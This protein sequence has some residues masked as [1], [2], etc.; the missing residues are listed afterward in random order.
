MPLNDTLIK[1]TKPRKKPFKLFD[2]GGLYLLVQPSG[3]KWWRLKYYYQRKE[4]LLSLGTYP[5]IS[6]KEARKKRYEAKEL[7][8]NGINPSDHRKQQ[9]KIAMQEAKEGLFEQIAKEWFK[10]YSPSLTPKHATK[11]KRYLETILFPAF[12]NAPIDQ[13]GP[14][15]ILTAIR[16]TEQKGHITTAHKLANLCNQVFEFAHIT[17]RIKYNPASGLSKALRPERSK[18]M[19]A[20]TRPDEIAHLLKDIDTLKDGSFFSIVYYLKILPYVFTRPSELRLAQWSEISFEDAIWRIPSSRMKMRKEHTVPL[21]R[22]VVELLQSLQEFSGNSQYLFP[23]ARANTATI[24]DAAPLAALRRLGYT[25]EQMCLHGFR[26]LASTRL[27][28]MGYRGDIIEAQLAHKEPDAVRLAYNRAE[29]MKERHNMM[30]EWADYL[31]GLK[32]NQ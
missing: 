25:K 16:P 14:A 6:L 21:A 30:Q 10:S 13:L 1:N 20:I 27:N 23:S 11:L 9:N 22:Q 29:Y 7:L 3:G 24:A 32:Q 5:I 15:E 17:G 2:W 4:L 31:D 12:G 18:N 26:A 28:E 19:A 8:A